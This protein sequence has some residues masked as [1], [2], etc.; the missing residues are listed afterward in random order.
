ME[1]EGVVESKPPE[2]EVGGSGWHPTAR[3]P[4]IHTSQPGYYEPSS[5]H[6]CSVAAVPTLGACY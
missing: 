5:R 1:V 4:E 3:E 6:L 2:K